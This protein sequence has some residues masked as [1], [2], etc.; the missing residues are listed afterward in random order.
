MLEND[1]WVK[2]TDLRFN[3]E[4]YNITTPS[5]SPDGRRLFFA[6]DNPDGHG[7]TDIY[8]CPWS[9]DFWGDPVNLG[10]A[11][12][13]SGN[14]SYPFVD[15]EGALYFS[16]DGHP[17]TGGKDIFYTKQSGDK[18][19]TPIHLNP[20]I[21]SKYDDFG[22]VADSVMS[23][24]YFSSKRGGTIDIYSF[25]TNIHQLYY[26]NSE[27]VN[28]YCFKFSDDGKIPVDGR[29]VELVWSF[30]NMVKEKGST[31]EHCFPG[32]GRYL[33]EMDAVDKKTG[34]I[35]FSKLSYILELS[36][37][38]QPIITSS[39]SAI[40]GES[41]SFDGLSSHFP[42]S[43]ILNYTWYFGDGGRTTGE[44]VA[45]TYL[46]K[47][48]YSVELGLI[49]RN[50][51]TGI[52]QNACVSQQVKILGDKA[53]KASFDRKPVNPAPVINI[54]DY[55]LAKIEDMYSVEK[56][57]NQDMVF[58]VEALSSKIRMAP[59]NKVFDNI[60]DKY[61]LK[62]I[63]LPQ[64]YSYSYIVDEENNLMATYPTFNELKSLGYNARIRTYELNDPAAREINNLKR[65]FGVSA[66]TFFRKNEF[67]LSSPGT[68]FLDLV[69]G[70]MVKYPA[71][72]LE[73]DVHSDNLGNAAA[74]QLLS[75]KRA[76]AMV[77]YLAANGV[78]SAR[79]AA[80]GFGGSWPIASNY[81]ETD[82]KL[83]RRIDIVL[84][85]E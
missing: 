35:F 63:F 34:E 53:E 31:V 58:H 59:D 21:N 36:D 28:Q 52:I 50:K 20:P 76:E 40:P 10:P 85:K 16:S 67:N 54:L 61:D 15:R 39:V 27:K 2:I 66:D 32:P 33:I 44:K 48:D 29:Y 56:E 14:E 7:G 4:Y 5:I 71:V 11:V 70:I 12:N 1:K 22:L 73:I 80:K 81:L 65:I 79:L 68:Q 41:L 60:P 19:L 74:N 30:G 51:N 72:K 23:K 55:D 49:V 25:K 17:G 46:E 62:E 45:H 18:W 13:T 47:G 37:Y 26:C 38:E 83:N 6:S 8:Y 3:N 42:G 43:D 57:Y 78:A 64:E 84:L 82:R 77:N 69:L 75:Q 9:G 24:G